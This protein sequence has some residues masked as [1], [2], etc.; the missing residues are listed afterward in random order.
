VNSGLMNIPSLIMRRSCLACCLSQG[1]CSYTKHHDQ[2]ASW[3]WK[4]L[5]SLHSHITVHH[6]RKVRIATHTGQEL[7]GRSWCRG[8]GGV[9]LTGLLPLAWLSLLPYSMQ[10]YQP[11]DGTTHKDALPPLITNWENALQL[12]LMEAFSQGSLLSCDNSSLC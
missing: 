7:E 12:D 5:F 4:G 9:L 2:E 10:N 8:H 6:Q 1:L 11:R 3:R